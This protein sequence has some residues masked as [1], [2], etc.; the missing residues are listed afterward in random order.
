MNIRR[1]AI[2]L[3]SCFLLCFISFFN[4]AFSGLAT[5]PIYMLPIM[6]ASIVVSASEREFSRSFIYTFG[7]HLLSIILAIAIVEL[8][9][10]NMLGDLPGEL[11]SLVVI[12]NVLLYEIVLAAPSSVI[13]LFFTGYAIEKNPILMKML[14]KISPAALLLITLSFH[15]CNDWWNEVYAVKTLN[16]E[17]IQASYFNKTTS[18]EIELRL[19]LT[20]KSPKAVPVVYL[21]Y[22]IYSGSKLV[23]QLS[24][25]YPEYLKVTT[26]GVEISKKILLPPGITQD[27]FESGTCK[28]T[29]QVVIQT[30]FGLSFI[31][32]PL[33]V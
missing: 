5:P 27:C 7:I 22:Y 26:Q 20:T 6:A 9:I 30:R 15:Q 8:P 19:R 29:V 28:T 11:A 2:S 16:V 12:R 23:R 25:N 31:D 1:T 17:L 14:R 24:D 33:R 10:Y 13:V 21:R 18:L 32:Y 3:A 4:S